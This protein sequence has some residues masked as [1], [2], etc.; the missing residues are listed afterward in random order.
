V[1]LNLMSAISGARFAHTYSY[2]RAA[3]ALDRHIHHDSSRD[4]SLPLLRVSRL[5]RAIGQ[6]RYLRSL[7]VGGLLLSPTLRGGGRRHR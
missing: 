1:A 5:Q 3:S 7:R 4:I 6:L 2:A